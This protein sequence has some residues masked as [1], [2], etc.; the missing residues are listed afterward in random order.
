MSACARRAVV[1]AAYLDRPSCRRD[2]MVMPRRAV[3]GR[4]GAKGRLVSSYTEGHRRKHTVHAE[5]KRRSWTGPGL[6]E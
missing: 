6:R 2:S 1:V 5:E 4:V 3:K